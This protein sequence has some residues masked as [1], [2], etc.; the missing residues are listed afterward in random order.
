ARALWQLARLGTKEPKSW[1]WMALLEKDPRFVSLAIRIAKDDFG[2]S[3]VDYALLAKDSAF[4]VDF[5]SAQANREALL[6]LRD[7]DPAQAKRYILN[8]AQKYDGKD[9]FYLEA[10]GIAVGHHDKAHR[11]II[12]ADFDQHFPE[13]NEKTL[14]L[15]W[16]L[17]PPQVLARLEQHLTDARLPAAQ[18][19]RIVEILAA[20]SEAGAGKALVK[21]LESDLPRE[22][23]D[24]ITRS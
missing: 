16:E 18:L 3:P 1:G 9:R 21:A 19:N 2:L 11:D 4:S 14:D 24:H 6:A 12:L 8:L 23:R 22:V 5:R 13:L 10:I 15:I 17:R 20:S 7:V